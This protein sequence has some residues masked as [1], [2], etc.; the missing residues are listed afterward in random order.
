MRFRSI[1]KGLLTFVPGIRNLLPRGKTYGTDSA[2]YCYGVWL[3]HL[4]LLWRHGMR[5][6]PRTIAELGP[7]DSLGI[8]LAALLSGVD[9]YI[10]LDVVPFAET[11]RNLHIFDA[12]A[13]L[14]RRRAARP[15]KGWPDFDADLDQRLF[16]SHILTDERLAAALE[17]SRLAAIRNA[18]Q[19]FDAPVDG[20]S[21]GYHAPWHDLRIVRPGSMDVIFSHAVLEHVEDLE[22]AYSAMR[23][24]LKP[25]GWISHQIDFSSH[26]LTEEWN[27]HWAC[28]DWLW[29]LILGRRTFLINRQPCSVHLGYLEK[30]G[31]DVLCAWRNTERRDGITREQLA[32]RWRALSDDDFMCSGAFLQACKPSS[33]PSGSPGR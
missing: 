19:S 8:G 16:P 15:S 31:F 13:E 22:T 7:G 24:W 28:P 5:E 29:R 9:R 27:G 21:I 20:I 14:F 6:M 26:G 25:G 2:E 3:K 17:P 33:P 18:L 11:D 30:G 10:A 12:L 1:A 4:T 32:S 23:A